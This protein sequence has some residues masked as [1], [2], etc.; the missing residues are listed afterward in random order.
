MAFPK[1]YENAPA[2]PARPKPAAR[3][4]APPDEAAPRHSSSDQILIALLITAAF[5]GSYSYALSVRSGNGVQGTASDIASASPAPQG[6]L[7][8]N[9]KLENGV[10]TVYVDAA[11]GFN[12]QTVFA[13]PD[14]PLK[15]KFGQ[16][17]GCYGAVQFPQFNIY[18]DLSQGGAE[19]DLGKLKPG[20]YQYACGMNMAFG[21]VVVR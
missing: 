1:R 21:L 15:I 6:N 12:P 14:I 19:V 13:K 2:K 7:D 4:V 18:K 3:A 11:N 17:Q 8:P 10:Q 9:A 16:G 20:Q 5:L